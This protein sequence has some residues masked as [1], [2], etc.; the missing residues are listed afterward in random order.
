MV[1]FCHHQKSGERWWKESSFKVLRNNNIPLSTTASHHLQSSDTRNHARPKAK[2]VNGWKATRYG[3][4]V[5][6]GLRIALQE[7]QSLIIPV[8]NLSTRKENVKQNTKHFGKYGAFFISCSWRFVARYWSLASLRWPHH[9]LIAAI[10]KFRFKK[11]RRH[12]LQSN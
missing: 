6:G 10:V 3:K 8:F 5:N 11:R 2:W 4:D 12:C 1:H 7:T 9:S